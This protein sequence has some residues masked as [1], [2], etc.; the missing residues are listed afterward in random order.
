MTWRGVSRL[1][2]QIAAVSDS[3]RISPLFLVNLRLFADARRFFPNAQWARG[4]R[5]SLDVVNPAND[6]QNV[7]D[8]FGNTP[9]QCQPACRH[10]LGRTI[11]FEIRKVF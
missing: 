6:R 2:T 4:L 5:L 11:E 3:L 1:D 7:P 10:P 8:W 9:L